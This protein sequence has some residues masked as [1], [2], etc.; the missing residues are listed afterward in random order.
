M[1][2]ITRSRRGLYKAREELWRS[3]RLCPMI[4]G[5]TVQPTLFYCFKILREQQ[6][7]GREL[8]PVCEGTQIYTYTHV[9]YPNTSR[10]WGMPAHELVTL[11][12]PP[13]KRFHLPRSLR[14][15][16]SSL[17]LMDIAAGARASFLTLLLASSKFPL[18]AL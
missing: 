6:E 7:T 4:Q 12:A 17:L 10:N 13:G 14:E 1:Q 5:C 11:P 8:S 18:P 9:S 3:C 2:M 16:S 15:N